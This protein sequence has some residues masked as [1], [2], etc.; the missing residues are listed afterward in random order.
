MP[1]ALS[2]LSV[3]FGA[4]LVT[5]GAVLG[6]SVSGGS[7]I[8]SVFADAGL[9]GVAVAAAATAVLAL[10]VSGVCALIAAG[11]DAAGTRGTGRELEAQV[12]LVA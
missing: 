6:M 8:G 7:E 2:T 4:A 10:V 3:V 5:V 11:C 9:G 12:E 1:N